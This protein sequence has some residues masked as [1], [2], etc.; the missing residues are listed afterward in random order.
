MESYVECLVAR[1]PSGGMKA[2][3]IGL[4]AATV[5]FLYLGRPF[6]RF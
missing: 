3:K 5:V 2:L 6:C 4:I 1:K